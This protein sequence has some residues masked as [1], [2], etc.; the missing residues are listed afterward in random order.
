[1]TVTL[2]TEVYRL[3]RLLPDLRRLHDSEFRVIDRVVDAPILRDH[4]MS[5]RMPPLLE[6]TVSCHPTLPNGRPIL[7]SELDAFLEPD[8]GLNAPTLS[9]WYRLQAS[10][11]PRDRA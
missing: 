4:K 5:A 6:G 11:N 8:G 3:E 2:L 9:S 1:M 7:T 10:E